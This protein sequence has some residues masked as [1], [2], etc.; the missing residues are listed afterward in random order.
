MENIETIAKRFSIRELK[1]LRKKYGGENWRKLKG[2]AY[3]ELADGQIRYVELHRYEC[4]SIGKRKVK[5]K[6]LLD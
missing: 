3:V 6:R 1:N 5:V 2:N 4:H